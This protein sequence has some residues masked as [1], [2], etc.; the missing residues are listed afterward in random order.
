MDRNGI[1]TDATIAQHISTIQVY[2]IISFDN[3]VRSEIMLIKIPAK[4]LFLLK[5][6]QIRFF[7]LLLLNVGIGLIEGYNDMGYQLNKPYLRASMEQ[8]C[9]KIVRG[10]MRREDMVRN[11]L[12]QMKVLRDLFVSKPTNRLV[13]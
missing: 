13:F 11:C 7:V 12:D 1:G 10:E 2:F 6:V 8:D 4:D 9:Q 5:E 3:E